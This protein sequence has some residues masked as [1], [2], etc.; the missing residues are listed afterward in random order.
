M[1]LLHIFAR[2]IPRMSKATVDAFEYT[3]RNSA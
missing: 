2:A 1:L 3:P